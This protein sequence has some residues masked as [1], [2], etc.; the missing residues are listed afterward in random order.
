[1]V[2]EA[3]IERMRQLVTEANLPW[4]TDLNDVVR[5][6]PNDDDPWTVAHCGA[7]EETADLIVE[8]VNATPRLLDTIE[9]LKA[10]KA[11]LREALVVLR[12]LPIVEN[13][14]TD[15]LHLNGE[16]HTGPV[17]DW[18]FYAVRKIKAVADAALQETER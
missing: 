2:S 1:M 13:D 14:E 7:G 5:D 10:D 3:Q 9:A 6:D 8:V 4:R 11:R 12:D 18:L 16:T 17:V 15:T